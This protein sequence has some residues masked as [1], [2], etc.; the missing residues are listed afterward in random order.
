MLHLLVRLLQ[1]LVAMM[2]L[3]FALI[4]IGKLTG[5]EWRSRNFVTGIIFKVALI[6]DGYF[7]VIL[8]QWLL[9]GG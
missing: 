4:G 9:Y 7:T 8:C 3:E 5:S 2:V 1:W 6:L